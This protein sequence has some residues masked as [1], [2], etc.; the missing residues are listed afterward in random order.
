MQNSVDVSTYCDALL[1]WA[2]AASRPEAEQ[3]LLRA[4]CDFLRAGHTGVE[5]ID[6]L[7]SSLSEWGE[8][9]ADDRL[10]S[11]LATDI[12]KSCLL[13]RLIYAG[14]TLRTRPCPTHR[15]RWSGCTPT[16][17]ATGC[18]FGDNVTGWLPE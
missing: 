7:C 1:V 15:G 5:R 13:L 2:A 3:V 8:S 4:G 10:V 18:S 9:Q 6:S 17:C 16:P 11:R 12:S 14:E